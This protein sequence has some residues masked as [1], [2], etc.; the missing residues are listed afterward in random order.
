MGNLSRTKGAAYEREVALELH[1]LTGI[2][3]A[4]NLRQYQKSGDDDLRADDDAWPF[5]IECKRYATA[6][7]CAPAWKKQAEEA[8]ERQDKLPAVCWRG[9]RMETR[10]SVPMYAFCAAFSRHQWADL[11]LQGFASLAR[12]IMSGAALTEFIEL[13]GGVE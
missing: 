2:N 12:E 1:A 7:T 11:S 3:F 10:V 9:D 4:R 13:R 8:A 5:A 6:N